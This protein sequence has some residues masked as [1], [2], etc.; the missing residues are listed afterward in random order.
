MALGSKAARIY[1]AMPAELHP[2]RNQYLAESVGC[3]LRGRSNRQPALRDEE[4]AKGPL[5]IMV[6]CL[7]WE[8]TI[9]GNVEAR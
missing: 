3:V 8:P 6:V 1:M 2:R 4:H 7:T 5:Q 9:Q